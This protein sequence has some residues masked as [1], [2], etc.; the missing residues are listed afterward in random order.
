[1][2]DQA[3]ARMRGGACYERIGKEVNMGITGPAAFGFERDWFS[4]ALRVLEDN[5]DI[6]QES[7]RSDAQFFLGLGNRQVLACEYWLEKSDLIIRKDG[8]AILSDFGKLIR[9]FD[10][11]LEDKTTWISI[12]HVLCRNRDGA[13]TYWL[14]F[15]KMPTTFS[16]EELLSH[17]KVEFP[18]KSERTYSD[19]ISVFLAI[20]NRTE[21]GKSL[22]ATTD[23]EFVRKTLDPNILESSNLAYCLIDWAMS[24]RLRTA[25]FSFILSEDGPAR[26][27]SLS[28][29]GLARH[30]DAIQER[31]A[32]RVLWVSRTAGL[33]SVSFGEECLAHPM[34]LLR[35]CY[36]ERL[37]GFEPDKALE[38]S[39]E[40]E[41]ARG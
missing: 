37:E 40:V 38:A 24:C 3:T 2:C 11:T 12:H 8:R 16:R 35:A 36:L 10:S 15:R 32:R 41:K 9:E 27:F 19:A 21:I 7:R 5:D 14:G 34:A 17:L 23:K 4:K 33:D 28:A 31:Y 20:L 25:S 6:F 18:G 26:P 22:F 1:M 30:L 39:L 29:E 13:S